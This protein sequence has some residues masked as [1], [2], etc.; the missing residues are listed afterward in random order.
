MTL[1]S[2][3]IP[4]ASPHCAIYAQFPKLLRQCFATTNLQLFLFFL[5]FKTIH[6][7][8]KLNRN[9]GTA[10]LLQFASW[11]TQHTL[12]ICFLSYMTRQTK[13]QYIS[14]TPTLQ[15]VTIGRSEYCIST[16]QNPHIH[17]LIFSPS[18]T[19]I[20]MWTTKPWLGLHSYPHLKASP[21]HYNGIYFWTGMHRI[22]L[23]GLQSYPL[24][25]DEASWTITG[26]SSE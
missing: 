8:F 4:M 16:V 2:N 20:Y 11:K 9:F 1:L 5:I 7:I 17:L 25:W 23:L 15:N 26:L 6:G 3:I 22:G 19:F 21:V 10:W 12:N 14:P 13:M 18:K 24:Y